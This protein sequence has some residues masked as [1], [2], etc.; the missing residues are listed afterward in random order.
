MSAVTLVV[1][2]CAVLRKA[3]EVAIKSVSRQ[4]LHALE[5]VEVVG[6]AVENRSAVNALVVVDDVALETVE[7][8][9]IEVS[10]ETEPRQHQTPIV[11]I[12]H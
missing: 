10:L 7:A 6:S 9:S 3:A 5:G 1:D 11:A 2:D 8:V 12:A 4:T